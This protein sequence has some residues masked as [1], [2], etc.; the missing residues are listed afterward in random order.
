MFGKEE[1][2]RSEM[3]KVKVKKPEAKK[4]VI[5]GMG[6]ASKEAKRSAPKKKE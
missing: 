2:E 3:E 6:P 5:E 1:E 4:K